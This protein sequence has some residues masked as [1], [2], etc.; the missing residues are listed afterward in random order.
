MAF[1][2]SI[3][4]RRDADGASSVPATEL[5]WMGVFILLLVLCATVW[6]KHRAARGQHVPAAAPAGALGRWM[7][8]L[9][10]RPGRA[11]AIV[12]STRLTPQHSLH[13]VHWQGRRLL[14][15][16]APHSIGVLAECP[17]PGVQEPGP[18]TPPPA[19]P[20]P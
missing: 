3:P 15:G 4:L 13:E 11:A 14:V 5:A 1:P 12:S 19:E 17:M 20:Q 7:A 9:Q 18:G 16:C 10:Q 2:E 8:R 6:R